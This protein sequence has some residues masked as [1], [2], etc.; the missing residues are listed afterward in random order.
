MSQKDKKKTDELAGL[1]ALWLIFWLLR[2][3]VFETPN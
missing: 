1:S 2:D 3:F